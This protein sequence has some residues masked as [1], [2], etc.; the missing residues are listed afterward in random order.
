MPSK[1]RT[2]RG[3]QTKL[4]PPSRHLPSCKAYFAPPVPTLPHQQLRGMGRGG[5]GQFGTVFSTTPFSSHLPLLQCGFYKVSPSAG[6]PG[7]CSPL[8]TGSSGQPAPQRVS[9]QGLQPPPG[10]CSSVGS[11]G[12][13]F[14][15]LQAWGTSSPS[16]STDFGA[17]GLPLAFSSLVTTKT[18]TSFWGE[19]AGKGVSACSSSQPTR[20]QPGALRRCVR[21]A[22]PPVLLLGH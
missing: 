15:L 7:Q 18:L 12:C 5:C 9:L 21:R 8:G 17:A 6:P 4:K 19:R 13:T 20:S 10:A 3:K 16:S 11:V 22:T 14:P 1:T 2:E